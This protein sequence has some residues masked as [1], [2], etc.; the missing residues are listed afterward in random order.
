MSPFTHF[1][2]FFS[3]FLSSWNLFIHFPWSI[4]N[5]SHFLP[6]SPIFPHFPPFFPIFPHFSPIFPSFPWH[7]G[8]WET[9][10]DG[11]FQ[12]LPLSLKC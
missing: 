10:R 9:S 5:N 4:C 7:A 2:P 3:I 1:P 11:D 8:D 6:F 12:G